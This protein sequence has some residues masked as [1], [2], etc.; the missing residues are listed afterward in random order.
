MRTS[1]APGSLEG[2]SSNLST[3]G[4]PSSW[5]R[6]TLGIEFSWVIH[7]MGWCRRRVQGS[8]RMMRGPRFAA[9]RKGRATTLKVGADSC[10]KPHR[11][12]FISSSPIGYLAS[13]R[14]ERVFL[15]EELRPVASA[16][17]RFLVKAVW[18]RGGL[19]DRV[20]NDRGWNQ[21]WRWVCIGGTAALLVVG[22]CRRQQKQAQPK[23]P[24]PEAVALHALADQAR[25][26]TLRWPN[27]AD[28]KQPVEE[29]YGAHDF[30]PVWLKGTK[31]TEQARQMMAA[32]AACG[33][34]GLDPED[35]DSAPLRRR[36][37]RPLRRETHPGGRRGWRR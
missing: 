16:A 9:I 32:F 20:M 29:F 3:S 30:E 25:L 23:P 31:P 28:L 27:F 14:E 18:P 33:T 8:T 13:I 1:P 19:H 6:T 37:A 11:M 15:A 12:R 4:P 22:G 10:R 35:Y 36:T 5:K 2:S 21:A 24:S 7:W 26:E 17:A 34:D